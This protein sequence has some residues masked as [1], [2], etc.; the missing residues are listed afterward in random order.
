MPINDEDDSF[1]E[2]KEII[3]FFIY[4]YENNAKL[5]AKINT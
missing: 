5:K 1:E 3:D 2:N 4:A